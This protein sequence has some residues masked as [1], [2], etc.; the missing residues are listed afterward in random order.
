MG[1]M[2]NIVLCCLGDRRTTQQAGVHD[3][4][5]GSLHQ[6]RNKTA[7]QMHSLQ[8]AVSHGVCCGVIQG[9]E[10][11]WFAWLHVAE[12]LAVSHITSGAESQDMQQGVTGHRAITHRTHGSQSQGTGQ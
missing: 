7:G 10:Q 4:G 11:V 5:Q 9:S 1:S 2:P 3:K 12:T 6:G 8:V